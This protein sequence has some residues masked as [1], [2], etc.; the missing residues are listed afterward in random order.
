[1]ADLGSR[2]VVITRPLAQ[3]QAFAGQVAALGRAA[4]IFPLLEIAPVADPGEL[5]AV[6]SMLDRYALVVFVS[7]NA[8]DA[9]FR[10][11]QAWP[12]GVAI[13]IVGEGSRLALQRHGVGDDNATIYAPRNSERMD[14]EELFK[15]LALDSLRGKRV[16]IVRGQAGRDFLTDML[17]AEQVSVEHATAYE[18]LTPQ[19]DEAKIAQLRAL[20]EAD[21]EWIVTSSEA[22]RNLLQITTDVLGAECVVKLQRNKMIVS[23]Q[24]IAETARSLAFSHVTMTGSGDE[25]LLAALQSRP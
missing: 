13:G 23:H 7:P 11:I 22:L 25:R 3:A 18:R 17:R 1:M 14:S 4:V 6:L 24:R 5:Q 12:D 16:L 8:V 2:P 9:A 20:I 15:A 19:M 10:F 21:S